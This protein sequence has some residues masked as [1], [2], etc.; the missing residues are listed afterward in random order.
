MSTSAP[1]LAHDLPAATGAAIAAVSR[2]AGATHRAIVERSL[3]M[4]ALRRSG[5]AGHVLA[6]LATAHAVRPYGV[7]GVAAMMV[8]TT[9]G[10][11]ARESTRAVIDRRQTAE[12]EAV[13]KPAA[14]GPDAYFGQIRRWPRYVGAV[15]CAFGDSMA[16][17]YSGLDSPMAVMAAGRAVDPPSY[18][19][20]FPDARGRL[21]VFLHGLGDTH[22][23]WQAKQGVSI[24][25]L[26]EWLSRQ[27]GRNPAT[28]LVVRYN[29]GRGVWDLGRQLDQLLTDLVN[30]WPT[31]IHQ[32]DIVGH[33]MG[34]L[35]T[36]AACA[37]GDAVEA[38]WMPLL[39]DIV[40]LGT[41]HQGSP[42]EAVAERV[43]SAAST[44]Q[45]ARP[46]AELAGH[47]S[48]AIKDLGAGSITAGDGH[49]H[50][51]LPF[52]EHARHHLIG[53]VRWHLPSDAGVYL[54]DGMVPLP[55]A[56]GCP[57]C[58]RLSSAPRHT[59][60]IDGP[61]HAGLRTNQAVA[62]QISE[63]LDRPSAAGQDRA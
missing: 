42:V 58:L 8:G 28:S 29:S 26:V 7:V 35:V 63:I 19:G 41:P 53:S 54:G 59:Y 1:A 2:T 22:T 16:N 23:A 14:E 45:V 46:I 5:G 55:S 39:G 31:E 11:I 48:V 15:Q 61:S 6:D 36:R 52:T 21:I 51:H 4:R 34:G 62:E 47:R 49:H 3:W 38:N 57:D 40:Y 30:H 50:E 33:S 20:C 60:R 9:A 43:V 13:S 12:P 37:Y 18:P 17:N 44:L 27:S 10:L 56:H 32:I 25:P 24:P